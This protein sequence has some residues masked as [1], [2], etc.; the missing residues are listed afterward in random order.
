MSGKT[1]TNDPGG[2]GPREKVRQLQRQLW[3]A[4]KRSGNAANEFVSIEPYVVGR[5]RSLRLKRK[6]RA[7]RPGEPAAWTREY[8]ERLGLYRLR[9]SI[10]Y[11]VQPF[12]KENASCCVPTD[13][14]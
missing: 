10:R 3:A 2:L 1:G 12:W 13:H 14:W 7:L 4:A 9:G 8:F 11:P 6:G 5:L